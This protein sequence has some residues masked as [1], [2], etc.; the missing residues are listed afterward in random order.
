MGLFTRLKC[1]I[2]SPK[3][4]G[5]SNPFEVEE[6]H[7]AHFDVFLITKEFHQGPPTWILGQYVR[8]LRCMPDAAC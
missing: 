1:F 5:G 4:P 6:I 3:Y 2:F 8:Q 7:I